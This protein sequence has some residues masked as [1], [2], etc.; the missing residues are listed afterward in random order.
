[1]TTSPTT[2]GQPEAVV[3]ASAM[4]HTMRWT[5]RNSLRSRWECTK[6]GAAVLDSGGAIYG[7]AKRQRCGEVA[8]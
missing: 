2:V 5:D 3:L 6:C 7:P 4:G 8:P 1:M